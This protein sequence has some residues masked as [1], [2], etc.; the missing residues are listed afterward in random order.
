MPKSPV[1]YRES[2]YDT[3]RDGTIRMIDWNLVDTELGACVEPR[4]ILMN[5]PINQIDVVDASANRLTQF[6]EDTFGETFGSGG[7]QLPIDFDY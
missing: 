6:D 2:F 4:G 3:L 1:L 7:Q 5:G